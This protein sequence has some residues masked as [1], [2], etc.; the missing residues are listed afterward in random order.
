MKTIK[1]GNR[2]IGEKQPCFIIAEAGINHDGDVQKAFQLI[3]AA[4]ESHADAIKFQTHFA[5]KE[6]VKS[7]ITAAYVGEPIFDLIKRMELS[8]EDHI[9][10]KKYAEKKGLVFLSTPFSREAADLLDDIGVPAFKIGSGELTNLPLVEHIARKRKPLIVSTG[11]STLSEIRT[12]VRLLKK[13]KAN[14]ALMQCT[15]TYPTKETKL[16]TEM[17]RCWRSFFYS[18]KARH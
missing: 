2:L 7:G 1:I 6:M 3:D 11:M 18:Q 13:L 15:S 14:F 12:T 16:E 9:K 17:R 5:E 8:K 4:A 10:L